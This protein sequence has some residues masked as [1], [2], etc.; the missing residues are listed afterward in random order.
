M[1]VMVNEVQ[2]KLSGQIIY[3]DEW[4]LYYPGARGELQKMI[5][6]VAQVHSSDI[7]VYDQQGYPQQ[8]DASPGL[9]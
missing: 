7:N 3:G 9:L 8:E 2:N 1:Q 4:T 6:E 5:E